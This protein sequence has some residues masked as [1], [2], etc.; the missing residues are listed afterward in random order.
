MG[1][2]KGTYEKIDN[3]KI[4][5]NLDV[6]NIRNVKHSGKTRIVLTLKCKKCGQRYDV[7][8][9]TLKKQRYKGLCTKCAHYHASEY[10]RLKCEEIIKRFNDEGYDVL[11]PLNKIKIRGKK[12]L[13]FTNV[14]IQ[15]KYGD[16]YT[17]NCNNFCTRIDYYRDLANCDAKNQ[18][19]KNESRLEYKVR[20]FLES[21]NIPYKTQFRFKDCR[22]EKYPLPF[23]FCLYYMN[24]DRMLIEVDGEQHFRKS[25]IWKDKFEATQK[26]DRRKNYYCQHNNIPLLRLTNLD[27]DAKS[28]RYKQMILDFIKNNQ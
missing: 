22:G 4:E 13:Y 3:F 26:N 7:K 17:T 27:I 8:W 10:R 6:I 19:L 5:N 23:D 25:N 9:D 11:T 20:T 14:K 2:K 28:E 16:T 24:E 18:M 1:I 21:Q 12:T 15:N